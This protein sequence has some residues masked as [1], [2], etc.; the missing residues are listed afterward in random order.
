VLISQ[1]LHFGLNVASASVFNFIVLLSYRAIHV[2]LV[3][4]FS[5]P[6]ATYGHEPSTK[7][8]KA[9]HGAVQNKA[10]CSLLHFFLNAPSK[11]V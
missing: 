5:C 11:L 4:K 2:F 1:T 9:F 10:K 6:V 7:F 3:Q 8:K